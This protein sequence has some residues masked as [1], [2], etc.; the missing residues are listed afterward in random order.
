ML[1]SR[2]ARAWAGGNRKCLGVQ[3]LCVATGDGRVVYDV[4]GKDRPRKKCRKELVER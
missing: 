4:K 1:C 3:A 2:S